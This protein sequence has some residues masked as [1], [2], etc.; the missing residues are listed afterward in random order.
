[1]TEFSEQR[2][3]LLRTIYQ[4]LGIAAVSAAFQA[5]SVTSYP[6]G[7][8]GDV[9]PIGPPYGPI[10]IGPAYGVPPGPTSYVVIS[11]TVFSESDEALL[12]GIRV[13][14]KDLF[15]HVYTN[16]SGDFDIYVPMQDSYKLKF[17]DV[18]GLK[19]GPFQTQKKKI[20]L[21]EI[22]SPL[23]IY[24]SDAIDEE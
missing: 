4:G 5:C 18:N 20:T 13:S 24:L 6:L 3:K 10:S 22:D 23:Y 14:V 9:G 16:D 19:N 2:R 8:R 21:E 11:G 7:R 12:Q 17:E 15:E 1:M